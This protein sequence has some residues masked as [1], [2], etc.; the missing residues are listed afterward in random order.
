MSGSGKTTY[1]PE[2]TEAEDEIYYTSQV[3]FDP[4]IR[5][6]VA[7]TLSWYEKLKANNPST[8]WKTLA[9]LVIG[10]IDLD[11][12]KL[13]MNINKNEL[14]A[15]NMFSLK[16]FQVLKRNDIK[17]YKKAIKYYMLEMEK[18]T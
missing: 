13:L 5:T 11:E 3:E 14:Y 10:E 1:K 9:K 4:Q 16:F 12:F 8:N 6:A 2:S 18:R 15:N 17:Q 7:K